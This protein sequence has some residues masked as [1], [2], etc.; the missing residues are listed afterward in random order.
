MRN[1]IVVPGDQPDASSGALGDIDTARD[2]QELVQIRHQARE[3]RGD[4]LAQG[5]L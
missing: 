4:W 5:R 3:P 1:L 2:A